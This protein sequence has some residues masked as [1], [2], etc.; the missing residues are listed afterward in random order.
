MCMCLSLPVCLTDGV[1]CL[2]S[3]TIAMYHQSEQFG[4]F[5]LLPRALRQGKHPFDTLTLSR[6][7]EQ[8]CTTVAILKPLCSSKQLT[9]CS[10]QHIDQLFLGP[11][12]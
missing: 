7:S 10:Q 3:Y 5:C 1:A 6:A 9:L 11:I 12:V 8:Y 2:Q 4:A